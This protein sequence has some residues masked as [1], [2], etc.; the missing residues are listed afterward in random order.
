MGSGRTAGVCIAT[1]TS[2]ALLGG[3]ATSMTSVA[4][5]DFIP[6][7]ALI[8]G[9]RCEFASYMA[10][11]HGRRLM[12]TDNWIIRGSLTLKIA[13]GRDTGV[14]GGAT[15]VPYTGVSLGFDFATNVSAKTTR[16]TVVNFSLQPNDGQTRCP[17]DGEGLYTSTAGEPVTNGIGIAKWLE[18]LDGMGG[19]GPRF[20]PASYSY[21][22]MFGVTRTSKGGASFKVVPVTLG[23]N[24]AAAR[25][26]IQEMSISIGPPP[27][28]PVTRIQIVGGGRASG[29][30]IMGLD[31]A[32]DGR[33]RGPGRGGRPSSA[34]PQEDPE[35]RSQ[36]LRL[37]DG[38]FLNR[39][40]R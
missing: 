15:I 40:A 10:T 7:R 2:A 14:T 9:I 20:S 11:P 19:G 12:V 35:L 6:A 22:L 26:D 21:A 37:Q 38:L 23:V 18:S 24:T 1:A 4:P 34:V 30:A 8:N 32:G 33:A 28:L 3:C 39:P 5:E 29:G 31:A 13:E 16:A 17:V 36:R 27:P 25:E